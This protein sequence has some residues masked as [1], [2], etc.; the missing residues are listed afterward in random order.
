[1]P[2]VAEVPDLFRAVD[3]GAT[4]ALLAKLAVEKSYTS[5][6]EETRAAIQVSAAPSP[7]ALAKHVIHRTCSSG[8]RVAATPWLM[9]VS[10]RASQRPAS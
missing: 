9:L 2:V 4:L 7:G 8:P 1:M 10:C 5:K 3:G 6:L